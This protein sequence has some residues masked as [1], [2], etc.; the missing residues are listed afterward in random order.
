MPAD[1]LA[2]VIATALQAAR[3]LDEE[4]VRQIVREELASF[5]PATSAGWAT[6]PRAAESRGVSLKRVRALMDRGVVE[7]RAKNSEAAQ[8]KMEILLSS[9]DAALSSDIAPAA[10]QP[11]NAAS[12]A[13]QRAKKKTAL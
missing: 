8:P 12:W 2:T 11:I 6:P 7:K 3:E 4:R 9:L 13:A 10:D 5:R 1:A